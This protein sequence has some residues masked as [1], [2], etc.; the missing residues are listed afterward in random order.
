M[1]QYTNNLNP[2][3]SHLHLSKC[4][5]FLVNKI[6]GK[7]TKN[8]ME[9]RLPPLK[10]ME[11]N[12]YVHNQNLITIGQKVFKHVSDST[13]TSLPEPWKECTAYSLSKVQR[14]KFF[15]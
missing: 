15:S 3:A 13:S 2:S 5:H 4:F 7:H 9:K 14:K 6:T 12:Q 8:L 10:Q 11:I 1:I